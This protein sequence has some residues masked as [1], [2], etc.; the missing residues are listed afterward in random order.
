MVP[1][2]IHGASRSGA[3]ASFAR[4]DSGTYLLDPLMGL[5]STPPVWCKLDQQQVRF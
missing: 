5:A 3:T 1:T 2:R 4:D